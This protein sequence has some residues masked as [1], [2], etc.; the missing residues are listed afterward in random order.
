V[1]LQKWTCAYRKRDYYCRPSAVRIRFSRLRN[2][3]DVVVRTSRTS[4]R[5]ERPNSLDTTSTIC[6]RFQ[7]PLQLDA[8][9]V[10]KI[11][12]TRLGREHPGIECSTWTLAPSTGTLVVRERRTFR[13]LADRREWP[14]PGSHRSEQFVVEPALVGTRTPSDARVYDSRGCGVGE[15]NAAHTGCRRAE[16]EE[17]VASASAGCV[18]LCAGTAP[19]PLFGGSSSERPAGRPCLP[20]A[21]DHTVTRRPNRETPPRRVLSRSS[22]C[23][24]LAAS[25]AIGA[26][27]VRRE[28]WPGRR[29]PDRR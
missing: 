3:K 1:Y 20:R 13:P 16:T 19:E 9:H 8:A 7:Q 17:F 22:R 5:R 10:V 26:F 18:R 15:P 2:H 6:K 14:L 12:G 11:L 28:R 21:F 24:P 4:H 29:C 25:N 27:R 23:S